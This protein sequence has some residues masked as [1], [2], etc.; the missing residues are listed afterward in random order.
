M[1]AMT[2]K[3]SYTMARL[4]AFD[5]AKDPEVLDIKDEYMFGPAFLVCPITTPADNPGEIATRC[6]YLPKDTKWY[7]YWTNTTY[8]GGQWV[9]SFAPINQLPL[10]VRAG[11]IVP[12]NQEQVQYD[13]EKSWETLVIRVYPGADAQFILYEDEGDNYN[14]ETHLYTEIPFQW[15]E[16]TRTLTIGKRSGHFPGYLTRRT[17]ILTLPDG[18]QKTVK[19]NG[20]EK[21]VRL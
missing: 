18:T 2:T 5:F 6:T 12:V 3:Q 13:G 16:A 1:A 20:S 11:S 14:Y 4:L 15:N 17:F 9:N 19:Y 8:Q 10:F 7:D 21:K